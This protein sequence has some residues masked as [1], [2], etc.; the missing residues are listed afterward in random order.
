MNEKLEKKLSEKYPILYRYTSEKT[1]PLIPMIFGFECGDGWYNIIDK[2]SAEI[3]KYN[4]VVMESDIPED[5]KYPVIAFQVKEKFGGL[6]FYVGG[7]PEFIHELITKA[8]NESYEVCENCGIKDGV[9]TEASKGHYW[10]KTLCR[11]C[12]KE[13]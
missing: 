5:D 9:E 3:E 6:R 12:R 4:K 11:F 1:K 8:E 13:S 7:A 2:L 10:I